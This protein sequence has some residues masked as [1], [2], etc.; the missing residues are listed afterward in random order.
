M[1][2]EEYSEPM[3]KGT[4][5]QTSFRLEAIFWDGQPDFVPEDLIGKFVELQ[6]PHGAGV[7]SGVVRTVEPYVDPFL[8]PGHWITMTPGPSS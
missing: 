7:F 5:V 6:W 2:D 4:A 8:G 1:T 3:F